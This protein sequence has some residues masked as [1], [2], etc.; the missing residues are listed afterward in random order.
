[1]NEII[2]LEDEKKNKNI[3]LIENGDIVEIYDEFLDKE[4]LEGNIYVRK[5][6]KSFT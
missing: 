6:S 3:I 5:N 4:R 2:A 1:M